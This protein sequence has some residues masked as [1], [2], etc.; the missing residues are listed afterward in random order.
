MWDP[1]KFSN[2]P[3]V[4][5]YEEGYDDG[6]ESM[7]SDGTYHWQRPGYNTDLM[8][9]VQSPLPGYLNQRPPANLI[10]PDDAALRQVA[11]LSYSSS[12]Y[13]PVARPVFDI[14][15]NPV[16]YLDTRIPVPTISSPVRALGQDQQKSVAPVPLSGVTQPQSDELCCVQDIPSKELRQ[17]R[18]DLGAEIA[19]L[20]NL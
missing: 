12:S 8:Y 6:Y 16:Q 20:T 7:D 1:H 13:A 5:I 15:T 3:L 19:D 9:P 2:Q 14:Q 18:E 11:P 10:T 4:A 17:V